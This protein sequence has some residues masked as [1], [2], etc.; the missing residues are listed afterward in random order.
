MDTDP[1]LF[2]FKL[3]DREPFEGKATQK[4]KHRI[5]QLGIKDEVLISGLGKQQASALIDAL[6]KHYGKLREEKEPKANWVA[7]VLILTLGVL[8]VYGGYKLSAGQ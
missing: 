3:P 5:W 6:Y 4:Q 7:L 8:I 2:Q 1:E